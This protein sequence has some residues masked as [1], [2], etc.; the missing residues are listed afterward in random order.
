MRT[1]GGL[2]PRALVRRGQHCT[3]ALFV[4]RACTGAMYHSARNLAECRARFGYAVTTTLAVD[5]FMDRI[6]GDDR[7]GTRARR[8]GELRYRKERGPLGPCGGSGFPLC[9]D[10]GIDVLF[11]NILPVVRPCPARRR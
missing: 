1:A 2:P 5:F 7:S 4:P 8:D 10:P 11:E 6:S 3:N 9:G